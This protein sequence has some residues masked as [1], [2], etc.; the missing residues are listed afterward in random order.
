MLGKMK[1]ILLLLLVFV[2]MPSTSAHMPLKDQAL[3]IVKEAEGYKFEF[4]I[5]P[6]HPETGT[7]SELVLNVT[8]LGRPYTGGVMMGVEALKVDESA[9]KPFEILEFEA[10]EENKTWGKAV[11]YDAGYYE[12]TVIFAANGTYAVKAW[13]PGEDAKPV[14]AEFAVRSRSKPGIFLFGVLG[15]M[16]LVVLALA[17]LLLRRRS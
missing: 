9:S 15:A 1:R 11:Q 8:Y 3:V 2:G 5:F 12:I 14:R 13:P 17:Y 16:V 7:I 10:E 4:L 6:K